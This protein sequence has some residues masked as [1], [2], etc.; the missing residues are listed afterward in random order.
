[1]VDLDSDAVFEWVTIID[2]QALIAALREKRIRGAGLDVFEKE[3]LPA[4]SELWQLPNVLVLPHVSAT[5]PRFWER[6]AQLIIE[7]F[8]RYVQGKPLRNVVNK[9]AGY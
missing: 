2:E 8:Q 4:D 6:Q 1:M 9:R 7:N 5:T 3:P